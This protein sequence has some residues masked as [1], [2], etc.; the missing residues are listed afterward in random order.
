MYLK[1]IEEETTKSQ[2]YID[3]LINKQKLIETYL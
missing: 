2:S 3:K 1:H